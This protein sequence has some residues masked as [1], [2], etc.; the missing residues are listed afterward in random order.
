MRNTILSIH[1]IIKT[2]TNEAYGFGLLEMS[3]QDM[4][5]RSLEGLKTNR[6]ILLPKSI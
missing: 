3:L 2:P 4:Q 5:G 1:Q 6:S